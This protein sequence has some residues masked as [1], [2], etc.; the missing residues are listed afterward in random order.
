MRAF[1]KGTLNAYRTSFRRDTE[2]YYSHLPVSY[3]PLPTDW[4][5]LASL[6]SPYKACRWQNWDPAWYVP[7]SKG[8][9]KILSVKIYCH[10][11]WYNLLIRHPFC[12]WSLSRYGWKTV[13]HKAVS[14][15]L[16]LNT[17]KEIKLNER[18][19][20]LCE[21]KCSLKTLIQPLC[22]SQQKMASLLL[23]HWTL[24]L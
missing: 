13:L 2:F 19:M 21:N 24:S 8:R 6:C 4:A 9:K 17:V 14:Y 12:H 16:L 11:Q 10:I 22:L 15:L 1:I 23:Y 7:S 18:E 3:F 5:F 20:D